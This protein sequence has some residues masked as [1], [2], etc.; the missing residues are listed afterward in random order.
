MHD[1]EVKTQEQEQEKLKKLQESRDDELMSAVK[2]LVSMSMNFRKWEEHLSVAQDAIV[3]K[4]YEK[5]YDNLKLAHREM[6]SVTKLVQQAVNL[7]GL[8]K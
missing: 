2:N 5:A 3:I 8:V 1:L 4:D 6:K 7:S